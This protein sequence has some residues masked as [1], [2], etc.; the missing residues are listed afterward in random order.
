MLRL[1]ANWNLE[2]WRIRKENKNLYLEPQRISIRLRKGLNIKVHRWFE[3]QVFTGC[4]QSPHTGCYQSPL[5]FT[6]SILAYSSKTL[7]QS[8][9]KDSVSMHGYSSNPGLIAVRFVQR[10]HR[11]RPSVFQS[12]TDVRT[13]NTSLTRENKIDKFRSSRFGD[14]NRRLGANFPPHWGCSL[15]SLRNQLWSVNGD[16]FLEFTEPNWKINCT[17]FLLYEII[18]FWEKHQEM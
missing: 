2:K 18:S 9:N 4:Y 12:E 11:L 8:N 10:P 17:I 5:C 3:T 7:H 16:R 14:F 1:K 13:Q 15:N 6:C